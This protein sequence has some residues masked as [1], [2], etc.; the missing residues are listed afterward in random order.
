ML[1]EIMTLLGAR[2]PPL[3][4]EFDCGEKGVNISIR[5]DLSFGETSII[6]DVAGETLLT[7]DAAET[8]AVMMSLEHLGKNCHIE[9]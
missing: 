3:F 8:N 1:A 5:L 2:S 7:K 6:Q 9:V 4:S